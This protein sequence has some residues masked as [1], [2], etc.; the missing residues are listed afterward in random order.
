MDPFACRN[1]V[2]FGLVR[3]LIG[4]R[5]SVTV[6]RVGAIALELYLEHHGVCAPSGGLAEEMLCGTGS[7]PTNPGAERK[8]SR[9]SGRIEVGD[10]NPFAGTDIQCAVNDTVHPSG[11]LH[12]RAVIAIA[13]TILGVPV[14]GIMCHQGGIIRRFRCNELPFLAVK[15]DVVDV[16][17]LILAGCPAVDSNGERGDIAEIR[18]HILQIDDPGVPLSRFHV[19]FRQVIRHLEI[20]NLHIDL[21]ECVLRATVEVERK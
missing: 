10:V 1:H 3:T 21:I 14:K 4:Q 2:Q 20:V 9:A 8:R 18:V 19:S 17:H 7:V 12:E 15:T 13:G 16:E 6:R 5:H 11:V